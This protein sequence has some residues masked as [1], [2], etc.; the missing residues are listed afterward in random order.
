MSDGDPAA[1]PAELGGSFEMFVTRLGIQALI[2]LGVIENPAT[3]ERSVNEVQARML[4]SDLEM[5]R[6]K[7][8]GNLEDAEAAKLDEVLEGVRARLA[9]IAEA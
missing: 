5:L 6:E 8:L 3:G 4:E 2:A 9:E 7:T 1:R